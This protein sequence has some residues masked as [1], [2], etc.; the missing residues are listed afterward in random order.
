MAVTPLHRFLRAALA[1]SA[2]LTAACHT[3]ADEDAGGSADAVA[4]VPQTGVRDQKDTGNCWLFATLGWV[5]SLELGALTE[6][7]GEATVAHYSPA[8]L[9]YWDWYTKITSGGIDGTDES[10]IKDALDSG[11]SWGEAVE[12]IAKWG[13][14]RSKDVDPNERD[15]DKAL[16]A[17]STMT[18]SLASG[19]LASKTAR[20]D[21]RAVRRELDKAFGFPTP[22][23]NAM[24]QTFGDGAKNLEDDDVTAAGAIRGSDD[25]KVRIPRAN[26]SIV[27]KTLTDA[28]GERK[29]DDPD[30]RKGTYA[31]STASFTA[32]IAR[33]QEATHTYF[34]RIQ[35]VLH[36]KTAV[37]IG[38][39]WADN[40]DEAETGR[41][42]GVPSTPAGEKDSTSHESII[43]DYEAED[44]PGFGTLKAGVEATDA[45]RQ[46]ALS[47][48][49]HVTFLRIKNSYGARTKA[50]V[51]PI[52][53][54]DLYAS[55]LLGMLE[56]C[57]DGVKS[58][59]KGC[60]KH[61]GLE[62]VVLPAGF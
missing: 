62:D 38:W 17:L 26:G 49:A 32:A 14:V 27:I 44:V 41:F 23:S 7:G 37:P 6:E 43:D 55:Y 48:E 39:Y 34:A 21:R 8:Y 9:D 29:G 53:Y 31:F 1:A 60:E 30:Q 28:I 15:A 52:G 3:T 56:V 59:G 35:K 24:E 54:D 46:A 22:L 4:T 36:T 50:K 25:V 57:P 61:R 13:V 20:K 58:G 45:Q 5:E 10:D 51:R 2:L 42:D 12:L 40:G 18:K 33:D 19:A 16:A 47:P 11:G